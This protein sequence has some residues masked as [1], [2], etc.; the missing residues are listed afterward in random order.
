MR[1]PTVLVLSAIVLASCS[2][3]G[4]DGPLPSGAQAGSAA[5]LAPTGKYEVLYAFGGSDGSFPYAG[6]LA[7]NGALYGTTEY[8]GNAN[9]GTVFSVSPQGSE[10]VLHSFSGGASDGSEPDA[11]LVYRD[12]T[13]YGTAK[14]AGAFDSGVVFSLGLGGKENV[15]HSFGKGHDGKRP[16]STLTILNGALYGTTYAGG[17]YDGGT[18]Y[19]MTTYGAEKVLFT[20]NKFYVDGQA[21]ESNLLSVGGK[22]YGTTYGGGFYRRGTAYS[23]TF[24]GKESVLHSFGN[25]YDG[26]HPSNSNFLQ[27]GGALYGTTCAGGAY[28]LGTI[29]TMTDSGKEHIIYSFGGTGGDAT[30]PTDGL[31]V[32]H[33]LVYG[34]SYSGGSAGSGTV[35]AAT[36]GGQENVLH[37]FAGGTDGAL[38]T[39]P[40]TVLKDTLYGTT[41]IGGS[42]GDGIVFKLKP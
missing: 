22:L 41:T 6:L 8:G 15:L 40:L 30:C 3:P 4:A 34:T 23:L 37:S 39:S 10:R 14:T 18:A 33:G 16:H 13:F 21:P 31:V 11:G 38:P 2:H 9:D 1:I 35:F 20:F 5:R 26:S 19:E 7:E 36:F 25:A 28:N 12:G 24:G 27:Y 17:A 42:S 32:L 29:F